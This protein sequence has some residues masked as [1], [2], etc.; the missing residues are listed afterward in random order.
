M[1]PG[2]SVLPDASMRCAPA[3]I[4]VDAGP[5]AV[6]WPLLMTSVPRSIGARPVP[7]MMRALVKATVPCGACASD[8]G[9]ASVAIA[10]AVPATSATTWKV[11]RIM[12]GLPAGR[13]AP[14]YTDNFS[15]V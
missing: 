13:E 9:E 14:P 12:R 6:T 1:K 8:G 2:T 4:A 7:S 5:T 11:V 15:T 3:G 10:S